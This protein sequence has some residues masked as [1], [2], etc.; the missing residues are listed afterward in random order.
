MEETKPLTPNQQHQLKEHRLATISVILAA[1]GCF[2][3][4]P[5]IILGIIAWVQIKRNPGKFKGLWTARIAVALGVL[6]VLA[7]V[8][9][10][11]LILFIDM[12]TETAQR[13]LNEGISC[14]NQGNY[15]NAAE[16]FTKA[17]KIHPLNDDYSFWRGCAYYQ[18]KEYDKAADDFTRIIKHD[19]RN[20]QSYLYRG[21][22]YLEKGDYNRA[23][24]DWEKAIKLDPSNEENLRPE[25]DE[26]KQKTK[27]NK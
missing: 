11:I 19:P 4:I 18:L 3:G 5:S 21:N 23:I 2:A 22:V 15:N 27:E 20:A 24:A 14:Y 7:I 10:I 8:S 16:S 17:F 9:L 12:R 26:A 25:I 6:E 13:H 1:L